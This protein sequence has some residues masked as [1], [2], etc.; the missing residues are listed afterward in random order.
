MIPNVNK[1]I[2][3]IFSSSFVVGKSFV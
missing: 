3:R 1:M 2:N